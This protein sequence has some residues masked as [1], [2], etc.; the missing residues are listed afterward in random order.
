[1]A[2]KY[3]KNWRENMGEETERPNRGTESGGRWDKGSSGGKND[4]STT[5]MASGYVESDAVKALREQME[6]Q[7]GLKPADYVSQWQPQIDNIANEILTRKDFQYDVN[8]DALYQQYKDRYMDLGQQAMMDTMGQAAALTGGYGNSAAQIAGQQAYQGYLKGLTDKIP[9]LYQLA[10]DRYNQQGQDMYQRYGLLNTQE[11][12]A[13]NQWQDNFNRWLAER[14][15]ST[16]RY[17]TERGFD[18]GSYRDKVSDAQWKE[19]MEAEERQLQA[20][21]E[22]QER[23]WQAQLQL[24]REQFEWQKAQAEAAAMAAAGGVYYGGGGSS[25]GSGG[26]DY[27]AMTEDIVRNGG[28]DNL[29]NYQIISSSPLTTTQKNQLVTT[30]TKPALQAAAQAANGTSSIA[31]AQAAIRRQVK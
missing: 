6:V 9:E 7:L 3:R 8:A 24:Q 14:D 20:Q 29:T 27:Y 4:S 12:N 21:L 23:Q 18:Y 31:K 28:Y 10:L 15:Y 2:D 25:G 19:Q 16:G 30:Y 26:T 5:P 22:A 17:D 1:M 13:Y 11:Q